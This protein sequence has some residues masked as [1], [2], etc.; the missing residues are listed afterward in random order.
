[1]RTVKSTRRRAQ[2]QAHGDFFERHFPTHLAAVLRDL[3]GRADHLGQTDHRA[4][5]LLNLELLR[6][7]RQYRVRPSDE[8]RR[9]VIVEVFRSLAQPAPAPRRR[10]RMR[11]PAA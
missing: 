2:R 3:Q 4:Y 6:T 1:M 5:R 9:E 10:S 7:L 11:R 8:L